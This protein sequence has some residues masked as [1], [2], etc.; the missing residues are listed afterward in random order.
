[1]G[2]GRALVRATAASGTM[3]SM[4]TLS[5]AAIV[6]AA[7]TLSRA[8][9]IRESGRPG[10]GEAT[11][12]RQVSVR[13]GP[14]RSRASRKRPS[15]PASARPLTGRA[16]AHCPAPTGRRSTAGT[17]GDTS[18]DVTTTVAPGTGV[19]KWSRTVP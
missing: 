19:P 2:S 17:P 1:M 10:G 15:A 14:P 18:T 13:G 5:P 4:R 7:R 16:P 6:S 12:A 3:M 11:M 8:R 9:S